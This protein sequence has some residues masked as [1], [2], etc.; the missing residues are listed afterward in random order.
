MILDENFKLCRVV[1]FC[2]YRWFDII[3]KRSTCFLHCKLQRRL[4]SFKTCLHTHFSEN[5]LSKS[6]CFPSTSILAFSHNVFIFWKM[7]VQASF[8]RSQSSLQFRNLCNLCLGWVDLYV[9]IPVHGIGSIK[10]T[11]GQMTCY[12]PRKMLLPRRQ[13]TRH[14]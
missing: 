11:R 9:I 7:G 6:K 2:N 4:W 3:I 14:K 10:T 8:K 5:K 13:I 12:C 1:L